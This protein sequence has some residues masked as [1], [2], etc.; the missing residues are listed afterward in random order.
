MNRLRPPR[1]PSPILS[2]SF[3]GRK[4][5]TLAPGHS[6]MDWIRLG[7]TRGDLSG[8]GSNK[9]NVTAGELAVHNTQ[10]D[11]WMALRGKVYNMT[12]YMEYHPGGID[13]LMRAAGKDGTLLFDE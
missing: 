2:D 6:L 4:R 1:E 9:I 5:I 7:R 8:V 11:L 13:E 12:P 10:K 3:T